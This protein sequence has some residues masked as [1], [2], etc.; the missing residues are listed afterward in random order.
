MT[1]DVV[2]VPLR[3]LRHSVANPPDWLCGQP[4]F[5]EIIQDLGVRGERFA[6]ANAQR[7]KN[8]AD[9][10]LRDEARVE[11]FERAGGG[12]TG[13]GKR[14]LAGGFKFGV[15]FI[16]ILDGDKSLASDFQPCRRMFQLQLQRN[17]A[18]RSYIDSDVVARLAIAA[19]YALGQLAMLVDDRQRNPIH[20][21]FE[22]VINLILPD[23]FSDRCVKALKLLNRIFVLLLLSELRVGFLR[24]SWMS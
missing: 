11:L 23:L 9:G 13:I 18:N 2:L 17:G 3:D 1:D 16:E 5:L 12:I 24:G 22:H 7:V 20:F 4:G 14:G 21:R 10:P 19:S 8:R 15:K 6:F